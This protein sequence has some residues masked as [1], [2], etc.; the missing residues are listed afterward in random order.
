MVGE[1]ALGE[2]AV[3]V[4]LVAITVLIHGAVLSWMLWEIHR[5][6]TSAGSLLYDWFAF[7]RVAVICIF[8]HL[9][10]IVVWALYYVW[11]GSMGSL[12]VAA[13]FSAVTYATI[14][15]GDITPPHHL[16]L[17][18]S[19]EG[20]TGILMCAW[21]GGFFFAVVTRVWDRRAAAAHRATH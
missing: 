15:Y 17:L 21:S 6:F 5:P 10:E 16:R 1:L 11:E 2:L 9:V 19:M 14:G 13:Y 12:D 7:V 8:A 3:G 20:L 18:A 4:V